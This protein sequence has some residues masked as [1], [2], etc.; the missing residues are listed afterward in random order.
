MFP[1]GHS[2]FRSDTNRRNHLTLAPLDHQPS[3]SH[4]PQAPNT[5]ILIMK[6]RSYGPA[7]MLGSSPGM[8]TG[9]LPDPSGGPWR[10]SGL[11]DRPTTGMAHHIVDVAD[12]G[13][14][15]RVLIRTLLQ[16]G[17][18]ATL[19]VIDLPTGPGRLDPEAFTGTQA[20]VGDIE[21]VRDSRTVKQAYHLV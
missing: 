3:C 20:T 14:A 19:A 10:F 16:W 1:D 8:A 17:L 6:I 21:V 13:A 18:P 11:A 9:A 7:G 2:E 4:L 12:H 15:C 5:L